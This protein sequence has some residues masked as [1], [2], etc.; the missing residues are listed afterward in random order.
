M[1]L[2][3]QIRSHPHHHR[4]ARRNLTA[5]VSCRVIHAAD[6]LRGQV[7]SSMLRMSRSLMSC[8]TISLR[9]SAAPVPSKCCNICLTRVTSAH[10]SPRVLD[11]PHD[12]LVIQLR[13]KFHL[14]RD[15]LVDVFIGTL[16]NNLLDSVETAVQFVLHL[17]RLR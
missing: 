9:S 13:E 17:D 16:E 15:L 1:T 7:S 11:S 12:I 6:Y 8:P 4:P 5:R 3:L 14:A 10:R 2:T